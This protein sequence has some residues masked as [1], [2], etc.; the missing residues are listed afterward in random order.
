MRRRFRYD[1]KA[2]KLVEIT[3][4]DNPVRRDDLLY[5]D[6]GYEGMRASDGTDISSRT[7]H[8]AYMKA[9]GL[10]TMD[11]FKDIWAKSAEKRADYYMGR[12]G[13]ITREDIGR[14]IHELEHKNRK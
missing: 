11:D 3:S 5:H 8:R 14:V 13:A 10:T 1:E 9:N 7:K 6:R 4:E 2:G 12:T